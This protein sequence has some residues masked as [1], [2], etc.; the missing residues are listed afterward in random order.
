MPCTSTPQRSWLSAAGRSL[1]ARLLQAPHFS[2]TAAGSARAVSREPEPRAG[3]AAPRIPPAAL[4]APELH[5]PYLPCGCRT[6]RTAPAVGGRWKNNLLF[7]KKPLLLPKERLQCLGWHGWEQAP[8]YAGSNPTAS[9]ARHCPEP[10]LL[11]PGPAPEMP[12]ATRAPKQ[13]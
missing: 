12:V 13:A 3:L 8:L 9:G 4:G 5:G 11:S 7:L 1:Q 2:G 6:E 10:V